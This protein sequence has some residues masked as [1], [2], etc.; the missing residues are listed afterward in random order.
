M[1]WGGSLTTLATGIEFFEAY[2]SKHD[3]S[4][5]YPNLDGFIT[6]FSLMPSVIMVNTNL[7]PEGTI[8]GYEDLLS[9]EFTGS[10][11]FA[12]PLSSASSY[13][14]L[15]NQ[16]WAMGDGVPQNGWDYVRELIIQLD[17][18]ML[19]SSSEVY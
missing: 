6:R 15:I 14:Q 9:P 12:S 5:I 19:Q 3:H 10:I 1:L 18:K 4:L 16:L 2:T 7:V 8:L 17:G 11:A 13:E